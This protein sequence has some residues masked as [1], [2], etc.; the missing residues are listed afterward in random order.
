[1]GEHDVL[2][3]ETGKNTFRHVLPAWATLVQK[4]FPAIRVYK[5]ISAFLR[6]TET[7]YFLVSTQSRTQNRYALL[8]EL[9]RAFP[10]FSESRKRSI[11][12][13]PRNPGRRTAA[14][15]LLELL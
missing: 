2:P 9:L 5:S 7:L 15:F 12:L 14:H 10:L 13:F 1:M 8:L 11:S 3:S 6:I 4:G